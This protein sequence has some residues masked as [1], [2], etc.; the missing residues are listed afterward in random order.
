VAE[1]LVDVTGARRRRARSRLRRR[2]VAAAVV[3]GVLAVIGGAFWLV[4]V[5]RVLSTDEVR[6]TGT[7][8][9]D[10]GE[11]AAAAAVP[12]GGPLA[13]VDTS[14]ARD[15]VAALPEVAEARVWRAW[16]HA[17]EIEV[18]ERQPVL[19]VRVGSYLRWVDSGGVSFHESLEPP[20]GVLTAEANVSDS[21]LMATAAQVV[22]QLP[23][24]VRDQARLVRASSVD[25]VV[26]TLTDGRRIVWGSG[27]DSQLKARVLV[28]LLAVQ[29]R[30]YDVSAPSHPTTR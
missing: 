18:T 9:L 6:V 5:S 16:P 20:P 26:I 22:A 10:P 4:A 17:V 25:S 15:R 13:R 19:V 24:V 1:P 3:A 28:P 11:V 14:G 7:V 8:V 30:E 27:E 23:P 2:L 21:A 29:A 12:L